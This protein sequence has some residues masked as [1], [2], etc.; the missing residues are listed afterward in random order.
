M[1]WNDGL[2]PVARQ[3]GEARQSYGRAPVGWPQLF[4]RTSAPKWWK[5][6]LKMGVLSANLKKMEVLQFFSQLNQAFSFGIVFWD[7]KLISDGNW[8]KVDPF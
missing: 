5:I 4:P 1:K 6:A 2:Y 8:G 3:R 7:S